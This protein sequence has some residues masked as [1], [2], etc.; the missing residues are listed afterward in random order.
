MKST[1]I[2]QDD[3]D[4]RNHCIKSAY[5]TIYKGVKSLI[6][7]IEEEP[8]RQIM[9]RDCKTPPIV[10]TIIHELI[11]PLLYLRLECYTNNEFG[12]HYGYEQ[13]ILASQF[14]N[15]TSAFVRLVYKATM[16]NETAIDIQ[17][18]VRTNWVITECSELFEYMSERNKL[19]TYK[20]LKYKPT[21]AKRKQ[22]LS[23]A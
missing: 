3:N 8:L 2:A 7:S 22:L 16:A 15:I 21:T 12:I 14:Y 23:V 19:H 9:E 5:V 17:D 4:S 1:P 18:C 11:S 13:G 6:S 20:V 10:G